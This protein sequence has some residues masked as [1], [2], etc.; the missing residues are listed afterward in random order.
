[1]SEQKKNYYPQSGYY[2]N[3]KSGSASQADNS[4]LV[5]YTNNSSGV[6]QYYG[7]SLKFTGVVPP[8]AGMYITKIVLYTTKKSYTPYEGGAYIYINSVSSSLYRD[9][10]D[11]NYTPFESAACTFENKTIEVVQQFVDK[12]GIFYLHLIPPENDPTKTGGYCRGYD[13]QTKAHRPY[14]EIT[15]DDKPEVSCDLLKTSFSSDEEISLY[16]FNMGEST[17]KKSSFLIGG[18]DCGSLVS[19]EEKNESGNKIIVYKFNE[20]LDPEGKQVLKEAFNNT[21]T[22]KGKIEVTLNDETVL[23]KEFDIIITKNYVNK[24]FGEPTNPYGIESS[25]NGLVYIPNVT[26]LKFNSTFFKNNELGNMN[27]NE[28]GWKQKIINISGGVLN[29]NSPELTENDSSFSF[30]FLEKELNF[31]ISTIDHFG[32]NFGTLEYSKNFNEDPII[33]DYYPPIIKNFTVKRGTKIDEDNFIYSPSGNDV[34]IDLNIDSSFNL[35]DVVILGTTAKSSLEELLK[36][37]STTTENIEKNFSVTIEGVDDKNYIKFSAEVRDYLQADEGRN[38]NIL[39]TTASCALPSKVFLLHLLKDGLGLLASG[40]KN[41]IC[42]GKPVKG[43]QI[44]LT[45]SNNVLDFSTIKS[46]QGFCE[47][48]GALS[49]QDNKISVDNIKAKTDSHNMLNYNAKTI[50]LGD[51]SCELKIVGSSVSVNGNDINSNNDLYYEEGETLVYGSSSKYDYTKDTPSA[52]FFGYLTTNKQQIDITIPLPKKIKKSEVNRVEINEFK[53][54]IRTAG[55]G[56]ALGE[57]FSNMLEEN[58]LRNESIDFREYICDTGSL[59]DNDSTDIEKQPSPSKICFDNR[60][61]ADRII[62]TLN[63]GSGQTFSGANNNVCSCAIICLK[64]TFC[65]GATSG[66]YKGE[67]LSL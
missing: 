35:K 13:Y 50:I 27:N 59:I 8:N 3:L 21:N 5:G 37:E 39:P 43:L 28:R 38:Y 30:L 17:I 56:Y 25:F 40:E 58:V 53:A 34:K 22:N 7:T 49:V 52:I 61:V 12:N 48:I 65:W 60:G 18:K 2:G 46:K 33:N 42:L 4:L 62:V 55:G 24:V 45:D 15:W 29:K 64:L 26:I 36:K 67:T 6:K 11:K 31:N 10:N 14:L 54:L 16:L 19:S 63:K 44:P 51:P 9:T 66:V 57:S 32:Y 20:E 41:Y 23:F 1:M 47:Q